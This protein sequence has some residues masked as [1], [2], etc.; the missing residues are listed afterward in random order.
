M[1]RILFSRKRHPVTVSPLIRRSTP[2]RADVLYWN[3]VEA[4]S[5]RQQEIAR[6]KA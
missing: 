3:V 1:R 4:V 6:L 2:G 5:P